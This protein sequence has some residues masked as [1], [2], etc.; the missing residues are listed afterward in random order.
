MYQN[1]CPGAEPCPTSALY[2][3]EIILPPITNRTAHP[4]VFGHGGREERKAEKVLAETDCLE[5]GPAVAL[6]GMRVFVNCHPLQA[7]VL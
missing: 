2:Q 6:E 3:Q 4:T 7:S 1:L 5:T